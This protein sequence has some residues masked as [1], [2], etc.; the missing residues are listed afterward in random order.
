MSR[1]TYFVVFDALG[2]GDEAG[3]KG[4]GFDVFLHDLAAFLKQA[5]HSVATLALGA[6]V[7]SF[8]DLLETADVIFGL[9]QVHFKALP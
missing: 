5:L 4:V 7:K 9:V 8:K 6:F 2:R 1:K 3:V